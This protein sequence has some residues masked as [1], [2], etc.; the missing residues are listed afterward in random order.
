MASFTDHIEGKVDPLVRTGG[1][2]DKDIPQV[3][4][5]EEEEDEDESKDVLSRPK[6][7][8][9]NSEGNSLH[10]TQKDNL[11]FNIPWDCKLRFLKI[12]Q[13]E[14]LSDNYMIV[15]HP[16]P[17][18]EG[19]ML[20]YQKPELDKGEKLDDDLLLYKDYSLKK[21]LKAQTNK[22]PPTTAQQKKIDEMLAKTTKL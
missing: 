13:I 19:E 21:R 9:F 14:T 7:S 5:V 2:K 4:A 11:K 16:F 17:Q 22:F 18:V 6:S 1:R 3:A 10:N 20:I 12:N 8:A 15:T